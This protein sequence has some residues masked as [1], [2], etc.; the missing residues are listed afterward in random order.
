M[1]FSIV[2]SAGGIVRLHRCSEKED[3]C[4]ESKTF[5]KADLRKMQGD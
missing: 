5:R 4:N 2:N 1:S 3:S